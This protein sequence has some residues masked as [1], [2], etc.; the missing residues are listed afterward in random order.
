MNVDVLVVG[1]GPA[2]LASAIQL[3]RLGVD[4]VLIVDREGKLG[5]IPRH[6][7]HIGFGMR[8]LRR[9]MT[10]PRYASWYVSKAKKMGVRLLSGVTVTDWQDSNSV[11][12]TSPDGREIVTAKAIILATGCRERPR[13]ARLVPGRR[14]AGVFTTGSLQQW[15]YLQKL[16]LGKRALVVGAEHV[17]Y[18]AVMTLKHA[19]VDV[20]AMVTEVPQHQSLFLYK[21]F[22]ADRFLVPLLTQTKVTNIF[23]DKRVEAVELTNTG[24]GNTQI[25]ACDTIVFTGNWIPDHELARRGG[26]LMDAG[27]K[28][29]EIDSSLRTSQKGVFAAGNLLHGAETA[30]A[31]AIEGQF[32]ASSVY[33]YLQDDCWRS[34]HAVH[35]DCGKGIEW[36]S[37][38][39][40]GPGKSTIPG[41]RLLFRVNEFCL[42]TQIVISQGDEILREQRF[43]RLIPNL[44]ISIDT[45]WLRNVLP[46]GDSVRLEIC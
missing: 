3:R 23:G 15:H 18:S 12:T 24:S 35:L 17:S 28:G 39:W 11:I 25:L 16:P 9:V 5:G 41:N 36:V 34:P 21:L 38:H 22:G 10:G 6:C 46:G 26:L 37:P 32:V 45:Q 31:A 7:R 29:P 27:T 33:S 43:N 13:A 42:D 8:D 4:H 30:D 2:G 44:P 40:I 19:G 1:A 14:V 20:A